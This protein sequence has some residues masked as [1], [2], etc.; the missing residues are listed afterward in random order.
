MIDKQSIE[1]LKQRID[2]V[3]VVGN[4]LELKKNGANYKAVCPFHDD[5]NPSLVIS[6]AKQIYHCF[7]CQAGGDAL[8]FVMEYDKLSYPEAI[9]KLANMFNFSLTYTNDDGVK[10]EDRRLMENL[11][12]F[13]RQNLEKNSTA[14]AYIKERGIGDASIEKFELGYAPH[15]QATLHY[16]QEHGYAMSEAVEYGVAGVGENGNYARFIERITFPI[17]SPSGKPVGFGGR[18][19]SGH[20]AKYVNSPQTKYFNKSAL[21]YGYHLARESIFKQKSIIVTEGYLD[22]IMLHQAGFT[23]AVATLGTAL[24]PEHIPLL[25]KGATEIVL[26]YDGDG[27]GIAA[28]LKASMLLST[29][30]L[31][32]GVVLFSG[33]MDPADM[34]QK[35]MSEQLSKLFHSPQPFVE[36][37]I[38]QIA[39]KYDLKDAHQKQQALEEGSMYL[40]SLPNSLQDS[41]SG[42]LSGTLNVNQNLIKIQTHKPK[43]LAQKV[44]HFEDFAELTIIKTVLVQPTLID[45]VLDTVD[46][47]MFKTHAQEFSLLLDNQREH[48]MLRQILLREEIKSFGEGEL[49]GVLINF[50]AK[51][52]EGEML[53]V[54][55]SKKIDFTEKSFL[56]RK[57]H[58]KITRLKKGELVIYESIGTF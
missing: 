31:K 2:I 8:K 18:T 6:P 10:K 5:S 54:K 30:G 45:T 14:K 51:F 43:N 53:K 22:V 44:E 12:L 21:L 39:R 33:G 24:T 47:L 7:S 56:M 46:V 19:I 16:L 57:L 27:A 23:N 36:F 35:G 15:S 50:L 42:V 9:E 37:A 17:Y 20:Q 58:D 29:Q 41:Y 28:A 25:S 52:Y 34:V 40:K 1:N 38:E 49:I 26:A 32:G 3:D 13:Y 4:Y 48:P 55:Q 11:T